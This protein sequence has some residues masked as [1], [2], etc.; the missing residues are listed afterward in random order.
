M[1]NTGTAIVPSKP[2]AI[3]SQQ[4]KKKSEKFIQILKDDFHYDII[5]EIIDTMAVIKRAKKLKPLEKY[6]LL[7][8]YQLTLL[9]YCLPKIKIQEST[10]DENGKGVTF[11]ISIGGNQKADGKSNLKKS[12]KGR[13]KS[14]GV[15]ISIPT[16]KNKDGSYSVADSDE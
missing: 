15:N 5:S 3:T 8:D 14:T 10:G 9:S 11:N 6:R 1:P 16:K 13:A 4:A 12:G 7:K 2:K